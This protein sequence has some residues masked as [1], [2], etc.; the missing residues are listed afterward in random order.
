MFEM[1]ADPSIEDQIIYETTAVVEEIKIDSVYDI[2]SQIEAVKMEIEE[3][4]SHIDNDTACDEYSDENHEQETSDS[5]EQQSLK[6]IELNKRTLYCCMSSFNGSSSIDVSKHVKL[7]HQ[8]VGKG[9]KRG[10][11]KLKK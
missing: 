7:Q 11:L 5:K 6:L 1:K 2:N 3:S 9:S 4:L 8:D 10:K